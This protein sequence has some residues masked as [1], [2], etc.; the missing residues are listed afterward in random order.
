MTSM[1]HVYVN[2]VTVSCVHSFNFSFT[3]IFV[4]V[5]LSRLTVET[6]HAILVSIY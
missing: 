6:F 2:N 4:L 5:S 1:V 3:S